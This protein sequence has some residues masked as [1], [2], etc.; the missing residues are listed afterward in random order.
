M[1][2]VPGAMGMAVGLQLIADVL[3]PDVDVYLFDYPGHRGADKPLKSIDALAGALVQELDLAGL[4]RSVGLYGNSMGSWVVFE[5]ARKLSKAGHQPRVVCVGD[6]YS[7]RFAGKHSPLRPSLVRR[8]FNK[9][10][11]Q[12]RKV[13]QRIH[14][15]EPNAI[16]APTAVRRRN[17]VFAA[18]QIARKTYGERRYAGDVIVVS[19]APRSQRFGDDLGWQEHVDGRV[20]TV[21]V[22]GTH[23]EM[24]IRCAREIGEAI[25]ES[26]CDS[27]SE[28][29]HNSSQ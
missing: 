11:T 18:S 14:R 12:V 20:T 25:N 2:L 28:S 19:T 5:A 27:D 4:S 6:M 15:P 16:E 23:D 7:P 8:L 10:R 21:G 22:P 1:V 26:L 24:H 9:L 3:V 13:R 17:A 29:P